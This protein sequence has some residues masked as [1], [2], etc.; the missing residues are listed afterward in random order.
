M[1]ESGLLSPSTG[2]T[3]PRSWPML[4]G[5]NWVEAAAGEWREITSPARRG[6]VL[7]R[8]PRGDAGDVD[9]AVTAAQ[10]AFP[11]WR[12]Q[13]F[14][15]RQRL[16]LRI[17][18]ALEG[19]AEELA[20]VTAEDTGNALRT[21]ARPEA[22]LLAD[23]FRYFGGVAGE[24]KGTTLPAGATQL[25]YTRQEPLGV[26]GAILPWNS[27]LMIAG[28][29]VPAALAAG[30]TI[31]LKAAEDAPLSILLMA[32]IC[33]EVLPPGVLNVVTADREVSELLVVD[34]RVDKITFT[35][36]TA[37]GR[38][39][40]SIVGGRIGRITLEL[41]GK[42]A[43]VVLDDADIEATARSLALSELHLSGQACLSLTRVVVQ[44]DKHDEMLE[45]IA[46]VFR[47]V[48]VGSALAEG[49]EMGPLA[50]AAQ[51]ERVTGYIELGKQSGAV[52]AAG[53]GRPKDLPCGY[54]VEPTVFGE[55]DNASRIAQEEIFGPVLSVIPADSEQEAIRIANDT[56]YGLY[57]SVF[58]SDADRYARVASD[59]RAGTVSQNGFRS[60]TSI[61]FGG[62]KQSGVG[63]EGG[64]EGILDFTET[65]VL[66]YDDPPANP[67]GGPA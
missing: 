1:S 11:A 4:I 42:S 52:L 59:I 57:G 28:F 23:L 51:L 67:S 46:E 36:S 8:V 50:T 5:G 17:A 22:A 31:V 38:R 27:P 24:V 49:T 44:R 66:L 13:H 21:Q 65:K 64:K 37:A 35:G 30:N 56:M 16:L 53:G 9:R 6:H 39:I 32:E 10:E 25:Q 61:A 2:T 41:G 62:F 26:V 19:R 18:D 47:Q 20:R 58:T 63:R 33:A 48:A 14:T 40:G 3:S 54:F 29:K 45:A 7:A 15:A 60:S 43:A 12:D 55:V 34:P